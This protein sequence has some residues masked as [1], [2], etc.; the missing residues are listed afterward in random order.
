MTKAACTVCG[1]ANSLVLQQHHIIPRR[2]GESNRDRQ[3]QLDVVDVV[4]ES[5]SRRETS[6]A[7]NRDSDN[8]EDDGG[9]RDEVDIPRL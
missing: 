2:F 4:D 7:G 6:S 3:Q 1:E 8:Q 5:V 9:I